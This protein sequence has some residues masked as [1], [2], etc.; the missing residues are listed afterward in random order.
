MLGGYS[1]RFS[2]LVTLRAYVC[3]TYGFP[4]TSSGATVGYSYEMQKANET[5]KCNN[6][7]VCSTLGQQLAKG[8]T[9]SSQDLCLTEELL[10]TARRRCRRCTRNQSC[11]TRRKCR[12]DYLR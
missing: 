4:S 12:V 10:K 11:A 7:E 3:K 2:I 5:Y 6:L 8:N 1:E 9:V